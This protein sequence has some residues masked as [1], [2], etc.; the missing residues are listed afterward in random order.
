MLSIS[1]LTNSALVYESQC[2]VWLGCGASANEY[3][4]AHQVTWSPNKLWRSTSILTYASTVGSAKVANNSFKNFPVIFV[5][6]KTGLQYQNFN[7]WAELRNSVLH[8]WLTQIRLKILKIAQKTNS[9]EDFCPFLGNTGWKKDGDT[10]NNLLQ[11]RFHFGKV[12]VPVPDLFS[13]VFQQQKFVQNLA[14]SMLETDLFP[15]KLASRFMIYLL[16]SSMVSMQKITLLSLYRRRE[17]RKVDDW[18]CFSVTRLP[19]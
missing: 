8:F 19:T 12:L 10:R 2:G 9:K 6:E 17:T 7:V 3:S 16:S 14:F 11:F 1:L 18:S 15:R 13:T 5:F 4:C